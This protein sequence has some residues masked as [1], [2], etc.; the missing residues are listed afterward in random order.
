MVK[1]HGGDVRAVE[2]PKRLPKARVRLALLARANGVLASADPLELGLVAIGLGAGRVR[3][4]DRVDP[5]AGIE[6][7]QSVGEPVE[8][9]EPIAFLS[10]G[11]RAV[12]EAQRKRAERALRIGKT[13]RRR[14]LVIERIR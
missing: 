3:A 10:G 2:N 9:G 4:D 1:A 13:A 11:S 6:L 14:T 7:C 8:R 12:V 5:G